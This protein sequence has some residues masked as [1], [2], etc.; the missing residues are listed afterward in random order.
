M[1]HTEVELA[2]QKTATTLLL[3]FLFIPPGWTQSNP[4]GQIE[5]ASEGL[6]IFAA[7]EE[8]GQVI[9][10][11]GAG[12][13]MTP[14]A[15]THGGGGLKWYLIKTQSGLIGWIKQGDSEQSKKADSF[16]KSLP[17]D[18][19]AVTVSIPNISSSAAPQGAIMVPVTYSR[20]VIT[21][22]VT[23]NRRLTANLIVDTGASMTTVSHRIAKGLS[24]YSTS[25]GYFAGIGGVVRTPIAHV[26]F[27][28]VGEAEVG[29]MEVS[30]QD[31]SRNP[32]VEGLLGMDFLGR[33][34]VG[35]DSKRQLLILSPR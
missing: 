30:I 8:T 15:E 33:Y 24:L 23:F 17:A 35:F 28:K 32:K 13:S 29:H 7:P 31:F 12:E 21:V 22:P 10:I 4:S 20:N 9:G 2:L 26:D 5:K 18:P 11:L 34:Q 27:V 3:L 25:S 1:V 6:Q 19:A 14:L 16:F